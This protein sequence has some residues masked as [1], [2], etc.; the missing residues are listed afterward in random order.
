MDRRHADLQSEL[1][2]RGL[3][4]SNLIEVCSC[5]HVDDHDPLLV[6]SR[7]RYLE[8][9][10]QAGLEVV[11]AHLGDKPL[12]FAETV[13]VEMAARDIQGEGASFL[14]CVNV[15]EPGRGVG[16]ALLGEVLRRA[17]RKDRGVVVDACANVWGFMP[18]EFFSRLGF[19][20]AQ[21]RGRR[22]L[23]YTELPVGARPPQYLEPRYDPPRPAK[24]QVKAEVVVDVFFTP[25]CTGLLSEEAAVMRQ[26]SEAYGDRVLVREWNAGDPE[27]QRRFGIARAIFVNG[28]MR[29]NDDII[30]LEEATA[31]IVDAL[32]RPVPDGAVWDDSISRLF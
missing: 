31:L 3:E 15:F 9:E 27:V 16:R 21:A 18:E 30:S 2:W 24:E 22:R 20:I 11:V 29:P 6:E 12:G 4:P 13:P 28:V 8:A 14:H 19:T 26:A 17:K 5:G 25:L 10:M 23:M 7:H 1:S 32:S